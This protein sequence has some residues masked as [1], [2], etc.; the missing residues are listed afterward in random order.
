[1][2][3]LVTCSLDKTIKVWDAYDAPSLNQSPQDEIQPRSIILTQYPVWRAR[4]LPFGHGV[5][6]LP[7][8]G[9]TTLEMYTLEGREVGAPVDVF[10][11]HADVVKEFVW[12]KGG[13]GELARFELIESCVIPFQQR[14][15]STSSLH[16]RKTEL[17]DSGL[18]ML[19]LWRYAV[20]CHIFL[21][22]QPVR[23]IFALQ[24]VGHIATTRAPS[25]PHLQRSRFFAD[26]SFR[27]P[28]TVPDAS[29]SL[30]SAPVGPRGIL[31]GAR[32]SVVPPR[33]PATTITGASTLVSKD[34]GH[35]P[36]LQPH[37]GSAARARG[38]LL[39]DAPGSAALNIPGATQPHIQPNFGTPATMTMTRGHT[40]GG[41]S[42]MDALHWLAS[43]KVGERREESATGPEN[44]VSSTERSEEHDESTIPSDK[45]MR[46]RS[47]SHVR[48][49]D[50]TQSLQDE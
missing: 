24:K 22:L 8:R 33:V 7:Q 3:D 45:R 42:G 10:E 46:K 37:L 19:I 29:R 17:S 50:G 36:I 4:N 12:R 20:T 11:G 48:D 39:L 43:I 9:G 23:N 34:K 26:K 32:A 14:E 18:L 1:M 2:H 44:G 49:G 35:N 16:G 15:E 21:P 25:H 40:L 6:S 38:V 5:L 31:A 13:L 30:I 28:P 47:E 27:H 41:M